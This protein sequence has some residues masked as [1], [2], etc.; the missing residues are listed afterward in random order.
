MYYYCEYCGKFLTIQE[1]DRDTRP[2]STGDLVCKYCN[3]Y[4]LSCRWYFTG[5]KSYYKI[6]KKRIN[7][8]DLDKQCNQCPLRFACW[9]R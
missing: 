7:F 8:D 5:R 1:T 9:T 6:A 3:N 2:I 4:V